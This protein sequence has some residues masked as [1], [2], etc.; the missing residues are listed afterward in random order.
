MPPST[1]NPAV[2]LLQEH[3]R[4]PG[5]LQPVRCEPW[6]KKGVWRVPLDV[7]LNAEAIIRASYTGPPQHAR[8]NMFLAYA[9][10]L[11]DRSAVWECFAVL[12]GAY[13]SGSSVESQQ[14]YY[15]QLQ[16]AYKDSTLSTLLVGTTAVATLLAH[17]TGNNRGRLLL[18]Y[19]ST[20]PALFSWSSL[21]LCIAEDEQRLCALME[22]ILDGGEFVSRNELNKL[23]RALEVAHKT[24]ALAQS[25]AVAPE[26]SSE[27]KEET[28]A[29]GNSDEEM[30]VDSPQAAAMDEDTNEE[31]Q[32]SEQQE[33][34]QEDR[35]ED[36]Q[37]D[38]QGGEQQED[39][40]QEDEQQQDDEQQED[41]PDDEEEDQPIFSRLRSKRSL[42]I[43]VTPAAKRVARDEL[44]ELDSPSSPPK[45]P[46]MQSHCNT[47]RVKEG[48]SFTEGGTGE[49][50]WGFLKKMK[51]I[52]QRF[53]KELDEGRDAE[54][55]R[56]QLRQLQRANHNNWSELAA[57]LL[58]LAQKQFFPIPSS[59]RFASIFALCTAVSDVH[60]EQLKLW[61]LCAGTGAFSIAFHQACEAQRLAGDTVFALD[62]EPRCIQA[63]KQN[64]RVDRST[65]GDIHTFDWG[66][67]PSVPD[68]VACGIPCQ[69]WSEMQQART[70]LVDS[71]PV[72]A[73]V[74]LAK[75]PQRPR[76]FVMECVDGMLVAHRADFDRIL[77]WFTEASYHCWYEVYNSADFGLPQERK[78]LYMAFFREQE[79]FDRFQPPVAP[80]PGQKID[81]KTVLLQPSEIDEN[82]PCWIP[83]TE[84]ERYPAANRGKDGNPPVSV[85]DPTKPG[86][87][88]NHDQQNTG[89]NWRRRE[90]TTMCALEAW[91]RRTNRPVVLDGED[92]RLLKSREIARFQGFPE[93]YTFPDLRSWRDQQAR[94]NKDTTLVQTNLECSML[95]NAISVPV[96]QAV[97][98]AVLQAF[99][100]SA[101]AAPSEEA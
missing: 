6:R 85:R 18:S 88:Y 49:R 82:D 87:L 34:R 25:A 68:I 100:I 94:P 1:T 36:E 91:N 11:R 63:V 70:G 51:A 61:D 86:E 90:G 64:I 75:S 10:N 29:D 19:L 78:R 73:L 35:Q 66:T 33:D 50:P 5:D 37:Q 95:G 53:A 48:F 80:H 32:G 57:G 2:A 17:G 41:E 3:L 92:W 74:K 65:V 4:A 84:P 76:A 98:T 15:Q 8:Q 56:K 28:E 45:S 71:D 101:V 97:M 67:L 21:K 47:P 13:Y 38:E 81:F 83:H 7:M 58:K 62:K 12:A 40:Q 54:H 77:G 52:V 96:A 20:S 27:S 69:K 31:Q 24:G 89:E 72:H 42:G 14:N 22:K 30:K 44:D 55:W 59:E 93:W 60:H 99:G 26:Q 39:E 16:D 79:E 43:T 46:A 23:D 9:V